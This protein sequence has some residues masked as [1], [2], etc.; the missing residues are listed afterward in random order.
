MQ[1]QQALPRLRVEV[2]HQALLLLLLGRLVDGRLQVGL[3]HSELAV[4]LVHVLLREV[5][6]DAFWLRQVHF[7]LLSREL[8]L[9]ELFSSDLVELVLLSQLVFEVVLLLV[10]L[11]SQ[12]KLRLGLELPPHHVVHDQRLVCSSVFLAHELCVLLFLRFQNFVQFVLLLV[13]HLLPPFVQLAVG[14]GL[15]LCHTAAYVYV[16]LCRHLLLRRRRT[17]RL[18][19][20]HFVC[21]TSFL[22]TACELLLLSGKLLK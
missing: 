1:A 20:P 18:R 2:L 6:L 22:S 7:A 10:L 14:V 13:Q 19:Q 8:Y 21:F 5:A 16:L 17:N 11:L 3:V 15:L 9:L 12:G 4:V